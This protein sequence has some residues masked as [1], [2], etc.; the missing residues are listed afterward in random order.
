MINQLGLPTFFATFAAAETRWTDLL[1]LLCKKDGRNITKMTLKIYHG[2]TSVNQFN[3]SYP[4]NPTTCARHFH[5]R[6]QLFLNNILKTSVS[7]IGQLNDYFI[8]VEFQQRGSPYLHCLFW[9]KDA[10]VY[11]I[12]THENVLELIDT[13]ISFLTKVEE[14]HTKLVHLQTHRHSISCKKRGKVVCRFGF[15]LP[16]MEKKTM[17]LEP[18]D[19]DTGDETLKANKKCYYHITKVLKTL[20]QTNTFPFN[21]S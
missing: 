2:W 12:D 6:T 7:L 9:V 18:L 1:L 11:G 21:S 17:I 5:Y 19:S 8:R 15:P 10:T 4:E 20:K 13:N 14:E 3:F 16:P